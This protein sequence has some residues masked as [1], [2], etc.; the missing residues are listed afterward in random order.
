MNFEETKRLINNV[1]ENEFQHI[2][3]TRELKDL[4]EDKERLEKYNEAGEFLRCLIDSVP[5]E[6]RNM[7]EEYD[8]LITSVWTDY[9]RYYFEKGVI[10]GMANLKFLKDTKIIEVL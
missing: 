10:S 5:E 2:Q 7:L 4:K 3:N 8:V 9:C 1:I 6:Y